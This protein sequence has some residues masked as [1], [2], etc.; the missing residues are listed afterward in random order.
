MN[1]TVFLSDG[2]KLKVPYGWVTSFVGLGNIQNPNISK[3][4]LTEEGI[5]FIYKCVPIL[6]DPSRFSNLDVVFLMEDYKYLH[7]KDKDVI[8]IE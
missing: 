7:V 8:D 4:K 3:L 5:S 6:L 1:L 2:R